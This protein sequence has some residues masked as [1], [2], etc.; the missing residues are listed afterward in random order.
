MERKFQYAPKSKAKTK[1][2]AEEHDTEPK[3]YSPIITQISLK[4][5]IELCLQTL[6]GKLIFSHSP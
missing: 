6:P 3:I 2:E 4:A 5:D 1:L